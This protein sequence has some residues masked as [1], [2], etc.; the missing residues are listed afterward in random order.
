MRS[1]LTS[2]KGYAH[3]LKDGIAK[4]DEKKIFYYNAI[5]SR[6]SDM[7]NMVERLYELLRFDIVIKIM[8]LEKG[9]LGRFITDFLL[10]KKF[11]LEENSV[12]IISEIDDSIC[13]NYDG[14]EMKRLFINLIENTIK[15]RNSSHSIVKIKL[16][17]KNGNCE[18]IYKDNGP[19]VGNE[20]LEKIFEIFFD[21]LVTNLRFLRLT[22]E[23]TKER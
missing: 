8:R 6:T 19:G 1:P 14:F 15:Y 5:L 17:Q 23:I 18:L 16:S 4:T 7:E 11:F 12:E 22:G 9:N 21:F 20:Y 2:I 13:V 10:E 3:G